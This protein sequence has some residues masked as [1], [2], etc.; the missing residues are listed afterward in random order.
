MK[1]LNRREFLQ[2]SATGAVVT[3]AFTPAKA[4]SLPS[5]NGTVRVGIVGF[6]GRGRDHIQGFTKLAN[7]EVAALCDVDE[8]VLNKGVA[9]LTKDGKKPKGY[10]DMRRLFE[11][12]DIDVVSIATPNHWHSLAAIWA[13]QAGKDVYVEKPCSHNVWEGRQLVNAARKYNRIVQHGTQSRSTAAMSEA[14]QKLNEGVIGKVYMARALCYKWRPTIGRQPAEAPP[15]GLHY[16][17][18][19][20]PGP[21]RPYSKNLVHYNWHWNWDFG[22]GDIGNQGVHQMDIA[23]R[24]LGVGLPRRIQSMGDHFL[25]DDDQQTPNTQIATFHYPEEKKMLVFEVRGL[26]TNAEEEVSV[27]N[28]FYGSDG[29]M[30]IGSNYNGYKVLLGRKLEPGPKGTGGGDNY[31]NFIEAVRSRKRE[32]LNAEIEEGHLSSALCHLA[33]VA[34]R[35]R[36][37]LEFDPKTEKFIGDDDADALLTRNYSK[38]FEVPKIKI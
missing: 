16:D 21:K 8:T 23:R 3:T 9:Q 14:M 29:I 38:G 5:Y 37:A 27:G 36:R 35:T 11:D 33:N 32:M 22:N 20:G 6:N 19:L 13:I 25:F 31:L 4:S 34:Y 17:L 28:I 24:G 12:K 15:S 1:R 10:T 18:W 30:V 2:A 7:V 26:I